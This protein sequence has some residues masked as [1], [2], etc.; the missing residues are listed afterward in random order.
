[1]AETEIKLAD[2]QNQEATLEE[3]AVEAAP[4]PTSTSARRRGSLRR[5]PGSRQRPG[6]RRG[7]SSQEEEPEVNSIA[8]IVTEESE[9]SR[10]GRRRFGFGRGSRPGSARRPPIA[11][12]VVAVE[13]KS[14][15]PVA[16]EP[17][18]DANAPAVV[19]EATV[20][21]SPAVETE[22]VEITEPAPVARGRSLFSRG[23][24]RRGRITAEAETAAAS[25]R[26]ESG[27][28]LSFGRSRSSRRRPAG[29]AAEETAEQSA[30]VEEAA[31]E[32]RRSGFRRTSGRRSGTRGF[33]AG[34]GGDAPA[35]SGILGFAAQEGRSNRRAGATAEDAVEET[36]KIVETVETVEPVA[37]ATAEVAEEQPVVEEEDA[38]PAPPV[39]GLRFRQ[40]GSAPGR[41]RNLPP[42]PRGRSA[43]RPGGRRSPL[44][45]RPPLPQA[46]EKVLEVK[47]V[48]VEAEEPEPAETA[49]ETLP[50]E[51]QP[52]VPQGEPEA[53]QVPQVPQE[54]R[55]P[56]SGRRR[57]SGER[58]AFIPGLR[59][60]RN[61]E[62]RGGRRLASLFQRPGSP[63]ALTP[64]VQAEAD[65]RGGTEAERQ[66]TQ[67]AIALLV[68]GET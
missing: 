60:G 65:G 30:T 14:E 62:R 58:R 63:A 27:G 44:F 56:F 5:R 36:V 20:D 25:S 35:R 31:P 55:L 2:E 52:A 61:Q 39:A 21:T 38:A 41:R 67:E 3:A 22:K 64:V 49:V 9:L 8:E 15:E 42:L 4:A 26:S 11:A 37:D 51:E 10:P 28:R 6:S 46:T 59:R 57:P 54:T 68:Q 66:A 24:R 53:P 18:E 7:A 34:A 47:T 50:E 45:S 48:T 16:T 17:T 29:A 32:R 43:T 33:L 19:A 1:M 23:G 13:D 12:A 40:R